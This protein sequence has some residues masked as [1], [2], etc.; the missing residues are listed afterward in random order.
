MRNI[1]IAGLSI[2][3]MI[4]TC[5]PANAKGKDIVILLHGIGQ[6]K[7]NMAGIESALE[8]SDYEVLNIGYPSLHN[9]IINLARFLNRDLTA[10][11]IW[12]GESKKIHFVTHSMGGLV[13]DTYLQTYK[14]EIPAEK[15]GRIVMLA[16]P[17]GGSEIADV[18]H[19]Y[20]LYK[21]I[22]GPAGQDLTTK[23]R[24]N[25][26]NKIFYDLGIIAGDKRWP[27]I[28]AA[29]VI[30]GENDGRV[31]VEKTKLDGMDDHITLSATHSFIS[32]KPVVYK[33]IVHF[34]KKGKFNHVE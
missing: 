3:L 5:F 14:D 29:H 16:P 25:I 31:S 32:W 10:R 15:L 8:K 30:P 9:N 26:N 11:K 23:N 24:A 13:L 12:D 1:I 4:C 21:W 19:D 27:Y 22:Y 28:I 17:H 2:S 34:L 7:W 33:Q 20:Q 18:L 6:S